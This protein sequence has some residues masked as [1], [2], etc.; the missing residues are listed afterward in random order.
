[1][2]ASRPG[3]CAVDLRQK[4]Q[5]EAAKY[6]PRRAPTAKWLT[7]L[8]MLLMEWSH[9]RRAELLGCIGA[10]EGCGRSPPA[11]SRALDVGTV[12]R[13][14]SGQHSVSSAPRRQRC[15]GAHAPALGPGRG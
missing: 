5:P 6:D 12:T 13:F 4:G 8:L 15:G 10:S 9:G 11:A 14:G 1:M 7:E 2:G 3:C